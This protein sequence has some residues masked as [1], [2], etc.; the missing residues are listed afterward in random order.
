MRSIH[1][2]TEFTKFFFF[3]KFLSLVLGFGLKFYFGESEKRFGEK[4][5]KQDKN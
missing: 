1:R 2:V 4:K 5:K 3:F